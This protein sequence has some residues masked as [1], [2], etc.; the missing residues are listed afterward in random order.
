MAAPT[1]LPDA[2]EQIEELRVQV[3]ELL[4]LLGQDAAPSA[5]EVSALLAKT[6]SPYDFSEGL[7]PKQ[8]GKGTDQQLLDLH[9]MI[10]TV[11]D[12]I[13]KLDLQGDLVGWNKRLETVTGF[14]P[15]ELMGRSALA[16]VPD[17]EHAQTAAAIRRAFEEG[18]AELEGHLLTKD[19]RTIPYH[20]TGAS[21]KNENGIA[22]GIAG[23][24]RDITERKQAEEELKKRESLITLMLNTGPGCIKRVAPDG[25]LLHMNPA[26]LCMIE[27]DEKE[28]L[29]R[30]VFDVVTPEHRASFIDMHQAVVKGAS[31]T[32]E[33]EIQ[34][35]KGTR[36]W[37]ETF[38]VPFLNP[39]TGHTEHLAV[40]H[41]ITTRKQAEQ[42]LRLSEE[43][44]ARATAVGKVGVWEL[45]VATGLYLGDANLKALFGYGPNELSTD[46]YEWLGLVHPDD[47][48]IALQAW[49]RVVSGSTDEYHYELRMIRKDGSIIWTDVRGHA[50]RDEHGH[51]QRLIGATVD[52]TERKQADAALQ[53]SQVKLRQALEASNTG[54]WDWNTA[55]NEVTFSPE[56][57]RQLGYEEAEL[58]NT[59][60][61]WE[62][63]LHPDDH[64]RTVAYALRYRDN[65]VG[66]FRQD[67]RLL[68]KDGTYRWIESH[69]SFVTEADGRRER[70]LG[71]HTDI[72]ELKR[73]ENTLA[74]RSHQQQ[75]VAEFGE[76]ALRERELQR[77]IDQAVQRIA[78]TLHTEYCKVLELQSGGTSFLLRAGVGW[79]DGLV[80]RATVSA[81]LESQAG[82]TLCS[83]EPVIVDNLET[84]RRFSG[85]PLLFDH[86]VVSG[87]S[88]IIRGEHQPW[89]VLGV[90]TSARRSF[91]QDDVNFA[92]SM[93][94]ILGSL[95]ERTAVE[96]TLVHRERE[97]RTMLD[98]LPIGI[99]F[100]DQHG[101]VLYGNPVGQQIWSSAVKVGLTDQSHDI[102]HWENIEATNLP[103]RWAIGSALTKDQPVLNEMIEIEAINGS[104]RTIRNS[105]VQLRNDTGALQGAI[106]LN[107]DITERKQAEAAL[108]ESEERFRT[109]VGNIPGAVYRCAADSEWTMS[110]LST[111]I[112]AIVGYPA[113]EFIGNRTRSYASVIHPDDRGLVEEETW[114][115]LRECR[116]YLL[117]Y[118]LIHANGEARWVIERGQGVFTPDGEVRFLDGA[119]FDITDR[120]R[121][122]QALRHNHALLSAIMDASI[123]I[124][125]VKDLDGRYLHMNQ[126]GTNALGM[127][128]EEIIGWDDVALWGSEFA[129]STRAGDRRVIESGD[130][131]TVEESLTGEG[132][133]S[134]YL[135][136]KAPYWDPEGRIIGVIGVARDITEQKRL[137]LERQ[138]ALTL[139][140]NVINATPDL[141]FAKDRELRTILCNDA[142]GQAIGKR[143]TEIIGHTDIENGWDPELVRGNPDKGIR[144]FEA[145]DRQALGGQMVHNPA[146]LANVK[147][148][149]RIF[150]TVK[151]P[152]RSEIGEVMG[153]LGVSRDITARVHTELALKQSES[154]LNEAQRLA[155]IGS[156]ELDLRR[157]YLIWSDEIFRIFEIDR[158]QFGAS[159]EAFLDLVHPDDRP[160]VDRAYTNSVRNRTPYE[161]THRLL[162][163]DGRVKYVHEQCETLYDAQG[164]PQRSFGTVQDVTERMQLADR[165][166][167]RTEQ[168][169]R[170]S[171]LSLTLAGDP[172]EIFEQIVRMIGELFKVRVVCLS[173]IVGPELHFTSVYVNGQVV[174]NAGSCPLTV[175]PCASVERDKDLRLF[176]HVSERFPEASFLRD[177][178]A[179][180]YCGFPALDAQGQVVAVTCLLDD[181]PREFAAEEQALLRVFGQR[182]AVEIER[183]RLLVKQRHDAEALRRS[184]AFL[185][186]VIDTTPNFIFA[187]DRDGRFTL[188][189]KA[190]ADAYG[191][192]VD[193]LIGKKDADFNRNQDEV[194]FSRLHDLEVIDTRRERFIPEERITDAAGNVRWL[195]TVKR[196]LL[197]ESG[198]AVMVLGAA[199]DITER[200]RMEETLRRREHDLQQAVHERERISEDLHDG[201]LQ[202][203][204]AI[205]LGLEACKPLISDQP[206]KSA[207]KLKAEVQRTIGQLKHV[208]EEVRNF[209][210]GLESHI[211]DGQKF[212]VVLRAMVNSLA[213]SY[214]IPAR[215]TVEADTAQHL[216]TEQ[217]YH[218]MHIAREALSNSFRHSHADRI[219]LSLRQLR[220][221]IRLS[222]TDNGVGFNP[223]EARDI[224]HG[225]A[226]MAARARK[227]GG[228]LTLQSKPR[229]GA[230]VLVD[231]P[232]RLADGDN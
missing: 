93:A 83:D 104:R 190:V 133:T 183:A 120:K 126:A 78:Q 117:E 130:T 68:H 123:D 35:F 128:I 52:I 192:T 181:K 25:T 163:P 225:L 155:H 18:Y 187:K 124:I 62:S 7:V 82:Y 229:Q 139:L 196:P 132:K 15:Q 209:I 217:A 170:L 29:G 32:L 220:R 21:L 38:A 199:T 10:E 186:Q 110:Y 211:L 17:H 113:A 125:H 98:A 59:F 30:C 45:D 5:T 185:R 46:P 194:N 159:Y 72:T 12:I 148:Q 69:A 179:V 86:G 105:A 9:Q 4:R 88:V 42:A 207:A 40:T 147:G 226:N 165:E 177:H 54:L 57:K 166:I 22:I 146:D 114:A 53:I 157:N 11:P 112:E 48:S 94:N 14:S 44:Y 180:S 127:P 136:T 61:S 149:V 172:G 79:H 39:L 31:R 144:G 223:V 116:P 197:N 28:A 50:E 95:I 119:I 64:A 63:R 202:S 227:I 49:E 160:A 23:V 142:F 96:E 3:R 87:L 58:P 198:E 221:S 55:T 6:M 169:K 13:F 171:E 75:V 70:L 134:F 140:I 100:T 20:W 19:A 184:H 71:S 34:G 66:A 216:S 89:G 92:Q 80:G 131:I 218:V 206:K 152:L 210:A 109:L 173:E 208:L 143:P 84:D 16:F 67:F 102:R 153:V 213:A 111:T 138:Q 26:G 76:F 85:P 151:V 8:A 230:T 156:W 215:V 178:S 97:L 77:V 200:K 219:R 99:W 60:E 193:N 212:D 37:M 189:N 145:D 135:T 1:T 91:T 214:S 106:V 103:H 137:E 167:A 150:D 108:L 27:M 107:E 164:M 182:I 232:R 121:A 122:E 74:Q 161:I 36:R 158:H 203:I 56:W 228:T 81:G 224:G 154:R 222:V 195:Q 43:R 162:M 51:V 191:T 174:R 115:S 2:L 188:V 141:I 231:I 24:G 175:T 129:A 90:H 205:G 47:Q 41:D 65:P 168:L 33:F 204:Y 118:R 201:I 176:D 101:H 73:V